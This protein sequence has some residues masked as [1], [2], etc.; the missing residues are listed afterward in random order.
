MSEYIIHL[1]LFLRFNYKFNILR[2]F[3]DLFGTS[4]VVQWL[5]L[6]TYNARGTGFIFA[7]SQ[8]IGKDPDAGKD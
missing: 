5:R 1:E 8:L 7:K 2:Y 3:E 4:Q 6:H